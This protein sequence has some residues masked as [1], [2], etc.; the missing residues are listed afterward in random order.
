MAVWKVAQAMTEPLTGL[1]AIMAATAAGAATYAIIEALRTRY[2]KPHRRT[3]QLMRPWQRD[4]IIH[5]YA[6][7]QARWLAFGLAVILGGAGAALIEVVTGH[8]VDMTR[9]GAFAVV[10]SQML[11]G[12]TLCNYVGIYDDQS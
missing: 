6:P 11:H 8:A 2:P 12:Y 5:L 3:W 4:I 9:S 1:I 10:V 7:R